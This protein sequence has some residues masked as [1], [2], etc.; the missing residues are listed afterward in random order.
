MYIIY[1]HIRRSLSIYD[2]G[3]L[4]PVT[5]RWALSLPPRSRTRSRRGPAAA[6]S[7]PPPRSSASS[8]PCWL[9]I[10]SGKLTSFVRQINQ[11][12]HWS[13]EVS[14]QAFFFGNDAQPTINQPTIRRTWG[15]M[16]NLHIFYVWH[17][18]LIA[19][20]WCWLGD[21]SLHFSLMIFL[22]TRWP[23]MYVHKLSILLFL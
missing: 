14:F 8:S 19:Y 21:C 1:K 20:H 18:F 13:I 16:E 22:V 17:N 7:T 15:L 6:Y 4:W 5:C 12:L 23:Y 10:L 3:S 9:T 2:I 11:M